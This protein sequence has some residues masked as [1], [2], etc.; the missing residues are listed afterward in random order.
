MDSL[1]E[2]WKKKGKILEGIK[3]SIFINDHVEEIAD[4]RNAICQVCPDIDTTGH[5]CYVPGTQPCCG[6]CGCSLKLLQR[7]LSSE[8]EN[9]KWKA[10]LSEEEADELNNHLY[11]E[12]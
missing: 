8:C 6:V 9:G 11:K 12:D 1:I 7:S 3:N 5:K 4:K 10:V 2:L